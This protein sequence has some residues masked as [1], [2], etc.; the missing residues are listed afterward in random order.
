[1]IYTLHPHEHAAM[2]YWTTT[3]LERVV[4]RPGL[5]LY[6]KSLLRLTQAE[7][8]QQLGYNFNHYTGIETGSK[9]VTTRLQAA[10]LAAYQPVAV[11]KALEFQTARG[12]NVTPIMGLTAIM[13]QNGWNRQE[14][15]DNLCVSRHTIN[16]WM[17]GEHVPPMA[18][19]AL[20]WR[21]ELSLC[22]KL[23]KTP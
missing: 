11:T 7:F 6:R 23:A 1:M 5:K 17:S 13:L 8:A 2:A 20:Y 9:P 14:M 16:R 3:S 19:K 18:V 21:Q 10:I 12:V 4:F 15:A 22:K